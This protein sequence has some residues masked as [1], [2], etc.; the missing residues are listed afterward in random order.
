MCRYVD[1]LFCCVRSRDMEADEVERLI[2]QI[3]SG[4]LDI[5][6]IGR[7]DPGIF[8]HI[9]ASCPEKASDIDLNSI[10]WRNLLRKFEDTPEDALWDEPRNPQ[11]N[12]GGIGGSRPLT[13]REYIIF[14]CHFNKIKLKASWQLQ[15]GGAGL[16]GANGYL[17]ASAVPVPVPAPVPVPTSSV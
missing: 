16:R 13:T 15:D 1:G 9:V 11:Q 3:N 6:C 4:D 8:G 7:V 10:N 14:R 17:R 2:D 5:N 12:E